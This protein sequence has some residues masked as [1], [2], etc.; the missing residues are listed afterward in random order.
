MK[1]KCM[2]LHSIFVA[3]IISGAGCLFLTTQLLQQC[4]SENSHIFFTDLYWFYW[5][6]VPEDYFVLFSLVHYMYLLAPITLVTYFLSNYISTNMLEVK[7]YLI[8]RYERI[9]RWYFHG[10]ID[11]FVIVILFF[12]LFHFSFLISAKLFCEAFASDNRT[13]MA[14]GQIGTIP[15]LILKQIFL[16]C[17]L[18]LFQLISSLR[19]T[20]QTSSIT[21]L[22][23]FGGITL[24]DMLDLF[25]TKLY[26]A[27]S[28]MLGLSVALL[29]FIT[30][31]FISSRYVT[32]F[33]KNVILK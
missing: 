13:I 10:C 1:I 28:G 22:S 11:I 12:V 30:M 9:K 31:L 7:Y 25:N 32:H 17:A 5:G 6:I 24:I 33:N 4:F 29:F 18:S 8:L 27:D 15:V 2:R 21:I 20:V 14:I 19:N 26:C 16:V 23:I 3:A